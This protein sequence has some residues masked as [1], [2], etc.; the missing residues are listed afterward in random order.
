[1]AT[2][3]SFVVLELADHDARTDPDTLGE[4][5]NGQHVCWKI[6]EIRQKLFGDQHSLCKLVG[7]VF[8]HG[9]LYIET[10]QEQT[11]LAMQ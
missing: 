2:L 1:M 10:F 7:L 9:R 8:L 4:S 5:S 11:L 3:N 6:K